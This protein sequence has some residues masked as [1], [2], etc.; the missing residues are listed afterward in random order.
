MPHNFTTDLYIDGDHIPGDAAAAAA[1][2]VAALAGVSV[3]W[4]RA[5]TTEQPGPATLT[6][7]LGLGAHSREWAEKLRIGLPIRLTSTGEIIE[8]RPAP[9]LAFTPGTYTTGPEVHVY[10]DGRL[11][12]K[13]EIEAVLYPG[14]PTAG[15]GEWDNL[16]NF[17]GR[18]W[19]WK[20]ETVAPI[21]STLMVQVLTA[22][23]PAGPWQPHD[24][25]T[26][27][28]LTSTKQV[29]TGNIVGAPIGN[30]IAL[31]IAITQP[32]SAWADT[33]DPW[34]TH[35]EA[36][37]HEIATI[38]VR[39]AL[40]PGGKSRLRSVEVFN[41]RLTQVNIKSHE[42]LKAVAELSAADWLSSAANAIIGIPP[43]PAESVKTRLDAYLE[44]GNLG[45]TPVW[46]DGLDATI[47]SR[48][49]DSQALDGLI[50]GLAVSSDAV[51]WP[52]THA[53]TG[54][55]LRLENQDQRNA[56]QG[57][58]LQDGQA[59]IGD[60]TSGLDSLPASAIALAPVA[61][62]RAP[63][64][65]TTR[66]SIRWTEETINENGEIQT[67][68]RTESLNN[69]E[70]EAKY[71]RRGLSISTELNNQAQALQL[72]T[73]LKKRIAG[74]TWQ[75]DGIKWLAS[76]GPVDTSLNL[77]DGTRRNAAP[78]LI[79]G[80]PN[81]TPKES[82]PVFIEGGTYAWD[83][84]TWTLELTAST[85]P[86]GAGKSALWRDPPPAY[87]WNSFQTISWT[88][89]RGVQINPQ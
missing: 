64:G 72:A 79:Q 16:P 33:P 51:A 53:T 10:A 86:A 26:N 76:I 47:I 28:V 49:V 67:T 38:T 13:R 22:S 19:T 78:Y 63:G 57:V 68:E 14:A 52:A 69:P 80:M 59:V 61:F 81:W 24:K 62:T 83:G 58:S 8:T 42:G 15:L 84:H 55:Y 30:F 35:T 70:L 46:D 40:S 56:A 43:R 17:Q 60:A 34:K 4:G 11:V 77:L 71:G 21:G 3:N 89:I 7:T 45:I 85:P 31:K 6:A 5:S 44:A 29:F 48:D 18:A 27:I 1:G 54:P 50:A 74:E 82:M 25:P 36:W 66:V 12:S 73:K 41:G 87:T 2:N 65:L 37:N 23:A 20:L 39:V 32:L 75:I 9:A 88:Q